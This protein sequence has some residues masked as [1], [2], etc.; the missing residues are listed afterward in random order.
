M[1]VSPGAA[2]ESAAQ[3]RVQRA[4]LALELNRRQLRAAF[5]PAPPATASA[6]AT[7]ASE[8]PRSATFR[9]VARHLSPRALLVSAASAALGRMPLRRLLGSV[10]LGRGG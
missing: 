4:L 5:A 10:L 1:R 3:L 7:T 6:D 9:W 8:F 2:S